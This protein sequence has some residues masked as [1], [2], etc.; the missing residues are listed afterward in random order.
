[1]YELTTESSF[2]AAHFLAGYHGKCSNLHGHRWRVTATVQSGTLTDSGQC[3]G[4]VVDFS[5]L[6]EH[7]QTLTEEMD[8]RFIIEEGSLKPAT[9]QALAEEG[10]ELVTVPFRPTA[11]NLAR[12]FYRKLEALGYQV[13]TVSVYETPNNCAAYRE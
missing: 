1:M 6:K 10:F 4:M 13:G 2:D 11:E 12:Y 5:R 9:L 8:H 7:L 3:R